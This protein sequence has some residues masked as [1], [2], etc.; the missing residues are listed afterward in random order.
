MV[1]GRTDGL[2]PGCCRGSII[3]LCRFLMAIARIRPFGDLACNGIDRDAVSLCVPIKHRDV[4]L[5]HV[6][7]E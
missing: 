7:I 6:L 3:A 4:L 2:L 1:D 5:S